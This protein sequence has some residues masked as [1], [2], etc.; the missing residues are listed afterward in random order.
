MRNLLVYY[1]QILVPFALLI[2]GIKTGFINMGQFLI[3]MT[4]YTLPYRFTTDYLRLRSKNVIDKNK[5]WIILIP[6]SR[7]KY[8][9]DL[10]FI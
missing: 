2:I 10:Y 9:K 5:F 3:L 8:F 7:I 1:L 6:G 4:I